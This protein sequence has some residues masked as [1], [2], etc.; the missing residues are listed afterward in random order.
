MGKN[1]IAL[2][3]PVFVLF[4]TLELALLRR[5]GLH[6]YRLNDA[7]NNISTGILQRLVVLLL[8]VPIFAGYLA[9]HAN[10]RVFDLAS[11]NVWTWVGCFLGVDLAYYWFHRLSH[12]VNFLWAGHVGHHQS[13][14]YNLA[15]ALRQGAFQPLFSLYFYWPLAVIGFPPLVF[16]ACSAFN[17]LYQFWLHT[18]AIGTLGPLEWVLVTPSHHRVHHG[19]N[20]IYIDRNHGGTF[21]VWDR[22]FGTFQREEEEVFYGITKPLES[23]NP[24]WA[25]LHY[26]VE[27]WQTA[28]RTHGWGDRFRVFL[29]APGW[30]PDE[31]GG[32][33]A[34]PPLDGEPKKFDIPY[35]AP[36]GL[37]AAL[38]TGQ[39]VAGVSALLY[40]TASYSMP[41]Q[42]FASA[43]IVWG[44]V[45]VG[46]LFEGRAWAY[47]AEGVRVVAMPLLA[48][49]FVTGS[50]GW[51]VPAALAL[52]IL[53]FPLQLRGMRDF[54]LGR[55]EAS[56]E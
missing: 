15:V 43:L 4:I 7:I 1:Y 46:G 53:L 21:V 37:Y 29:K 34:P 16:A 40:F 51:W 6:Y 25:N 56:T 3:I 48:S 33:R 22:L 26:W 14:E 27:M 50:A 28:R 23:W 47:R 49:L 35:P 54:F 13:E 31:L 12:E 10:L 36:L 38:Q 30:F 9:L 42:W 41:Y 45:N 8:A 5:R 17:T 24:I 2:A 18:R 39:I 55:A 20:P 44:L 19:R 32:Y 52:N 11:D